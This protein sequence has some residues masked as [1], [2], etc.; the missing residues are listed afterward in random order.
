MVYVEADGEP[1]HRVGL[2]AGLADK[3][4]AT[5]IGIAAA[6]FRSPMVV[7][8]VGLPGAA[9]AEIKATSEKLAGKGKWFREIA[10]AYHRKLEWR[11]VFDFPA[12]A[13]AQEARSADLVAIGRTAGPGDPYRSL[14][15][16]DVLLCVGRPTLVVP[17][18]AA[19]LL[20]ENIVIGW[21][22]TREARR[23]V[24]DSLPFLH[25][26]KRVTIVEICQAGDETATQTRIDD[27][28]RYLARHRIKTSLRVILH[29]HGSGAAQLI[30]L[31]RDEGA[32]LLATG[33]Y[34]H[35]RLGEW[36]FG[37]VTHDLMAGSPIC[38]L[39][40]H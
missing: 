3:L 7:E 10:G 14:D 36:I 34:G 28:A 32:D 12:T 37:G 19:S 8:A 5:L 4:N 31:A 17:D 1:A 6:A 40:S 11:P 38:C 18:E 20:A 25:D 2:C 9:D 22:D 26:A 27:V 33:A 39:M 23:V 15:P 30:Q 13:L 21:K 29:Q 16:G 24:Q 35:S